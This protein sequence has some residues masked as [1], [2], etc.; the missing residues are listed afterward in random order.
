MLRSDDNSSELENLVMGSVV[1]NVNCQ[2]DKTPDDQPPGMLVGD[3]LDSVEEE[4][5]TQP[6]CREHL[7]LN[8]ILDYLRVGKLIQILPC[9]HSS[10]FSSAC[11]DQ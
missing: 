10:L 1:V 11:C 9:V 7:S 2:C 5:K 4:R 8:R 3:C 6:L